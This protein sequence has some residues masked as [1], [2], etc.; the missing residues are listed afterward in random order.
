MKSISLNYRDLRAFPCLSG[1]S[2]E[3]FAIIGKKAGL[4]AISKNDV[5]F[6][7]GEPVKFL[8]IL[9]E[10]AIKLSNISRDGRELII[11]IMKPHDYFCCA[12]LLTGGKSLVNATAI[13]DSTIITI[14]GDYLKKILFN[15]INESCLSIITTLCSKIGHLSNIIKDLTF[16]DVE[17][18]IIITLLK[19]TDS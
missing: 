8:F 16:E 18:R 5:L 19:L 7:E 10:G 12:P 1:L 2:D 17:H 3:D 13:D 9:E 4:K 15:E 11:R 6:I 14:P